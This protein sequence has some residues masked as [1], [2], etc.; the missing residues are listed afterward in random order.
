MRALAD[1]GNALLSPG[2][3]TDLLLYQARRDGER[4]VP[5]PEALEALYAGIREAAPQLKVLHMD[6]IN[7]ATIADYPAEAERALRAI[8][9]TIRRGY[10]RLWPGICRPAVLA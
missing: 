1:L 5:N 9:R 6:N 10:R 2:A 4:L 8:A 3:Q 7:P